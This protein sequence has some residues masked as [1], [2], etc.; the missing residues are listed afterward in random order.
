MMRKS[1]LVSMCP[2]HCLWKMMALVSQGHHNTGRAHEDQIIEELI[3]E[4]LIIDAWMISVRLPA[5]IRMLV[6][7]AN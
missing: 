2:P 5:R 1:D 6:L 7:M 3:I 4:E